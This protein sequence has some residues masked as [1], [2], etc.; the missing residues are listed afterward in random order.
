L[1]FL[2]YTIQL[3]PCKAIENKGLFCPYLPETSI[4]TIRGFQMAPA[5][6]EKE[7]TKWEILA[8]MC[9]FSFGIIAGL[10]LAPLL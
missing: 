2:K 1:A 10:L 3:E 8:Y 6:T 9:G 7:M 4:E 5:P